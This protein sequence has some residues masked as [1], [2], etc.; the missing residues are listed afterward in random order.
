MRYICTSIVATLALVGTS[1][2]ATI[3]VPGDYALIQDAINASAGGDVIA[4]A[5]GTYSEACLNP[6]GRAIT[7]QGTLNSDGS[8]ATTIDAASYCPIFVLN[9]GNGDGLVIKDL[10][11]TG[12]NYSFRRWDLLHDPGHPNHHRLHD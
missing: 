5:A 7:I 9:S 2:A 6:D 4:I 11:I 12:G 10:V 8:L 1:F 3:N